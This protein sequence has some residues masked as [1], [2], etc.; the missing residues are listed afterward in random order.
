[1]AAADG[2]PLGGMLGGDREQHDAEL[3]KDLA[4]KLD[5]VSASDVQKAL[6]EVRRDHISEHRRQMAAELAAELDG[7]SQADVEKALAKLEAKAEQRIERGRWRPP[8]GGFAADL[9]GEL[10]K[11]T[12]EVRKALRAARKKHF[13][14][15]LDQA[16]KDGRI[17]R[18]QADKI[19]KRF[20]NGPPGFGRGPRGGHRRFGVGP[21]PVGPPP[22]GPGGFETPAPPP[23]GQ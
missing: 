7:V 19:E 12:A 18:A 16:V 11:S 2:G 17:T 5:G 13:Q 8:R 6:G 22:G 20:E 21:G 23:P 9:A 4:S 1:M 10:G 14:A 3:A 15:Q